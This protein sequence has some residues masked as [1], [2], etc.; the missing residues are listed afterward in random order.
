MPE[1]K[2]EE[3]TDHCYALKR[4]VFRIIGW[5]VSA[6]DNPDTIVREKNGSAK[7]THKDHAING[8]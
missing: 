5:W 1:E 8:N 7:P 4:I 2:D 3:A 6:N